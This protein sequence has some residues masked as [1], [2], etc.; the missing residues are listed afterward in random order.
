VSNR[1]PIKSEAD[2]TARRANEYRRRAAKL[3]EEA[4]R[5]RDAADHRYMLD[6]AEGYARAAGQLVRSPSLRSGTKQAV[7]G[8]SAGYQI[9]TR[10]N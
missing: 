10:T 6:L 9:R 4:Q 1:C 3:T 7:V 2:R 5:A 8:L